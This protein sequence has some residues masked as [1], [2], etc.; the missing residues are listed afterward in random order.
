MGLQ[1]PPDIGDEWRDAGAL[2]P[3]ALYS[4]VD[5]AAQILDRIVPGVLHMVQ[6]ARQKVDSSSA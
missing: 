6:H 2:S 3:V 5:E 1:P 4:M